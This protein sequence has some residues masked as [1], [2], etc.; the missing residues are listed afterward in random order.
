MNIKV[1]AFTVSEKSINT[2]SITPNEQNQTHNNELSRLKF[3]YIS[4]M[5]KGINN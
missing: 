3:N 4:S 5:F 2:I 1:A